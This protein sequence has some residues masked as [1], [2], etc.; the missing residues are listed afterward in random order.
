MNGITETTIASLPIAIVD[1]ETTG[2]HPRGDRV[3]EIGIVRI[4]PGGPP[5]LVLDT[6]LNPGGPV[7]AT[8]IHGITDADVRDAPRFEQVASVVHDALAGCVFA[9]FNVY[10]DAKF[11]RAE[12]ERTGVAAFPPHLCLM[13]LRPLLGIGKRCTLSDACHA[14][15]VVHS[16]AH[17]AAD[18]AL[19]SARLWLAYLEKMEALAIRTF[20][21]LARR[22]SYKFTASFKDPLTIASDPRATFRGFKSRRRPLGAA[23]VVQRPER[24]RQ[25]RLAEYWDALKSVLADLD[26]SDPEIRYLERKRD[27][28]RLTAGEVRTLHARAFAGILADVTDDHDIDDR[29]VARVAGMAAAL[30]R[31][32][33]SPGDRL[34]AGEGVRSSERP[35]W[36]AR[37]FGR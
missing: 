20:S 24:T 13:Y 9:S 27:D 18:D 3:I 2:L 28:L 30:R 32:G 15:D 37:L 21:D 22:K 17:F 1:V 11:V 14:H 12:F 4:E 29:E 25:D 5:E 23:Q 36:L 8:E 33:W 10:F 6:L 31:L 16:N 19:A 26:A 35:G 34:H 7:S